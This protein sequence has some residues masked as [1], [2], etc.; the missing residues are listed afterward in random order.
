MG[1]ARNM[2]NTNHVTIL[3]LVAAFATAIYSDD[4]TAPQEA[5]VQTTSIDDN[6]DLIHEHARSKVTALLQAGKTNSECKDLADASIKG[7]TDSITASKQTLGSL[8]TGG[9]CVSSNLVAQAKAAL[10]AAKAT[11]VAAS[12]ADAASQTAPV[13]FADINIV[14]MNEGD[15]A[16]FFN[17]QAYLSAKSA[18]AATAAKN[19]QAIGAQKAAQKAYDDAVAADRAAMRD[20]ACKVQKRLNEAWPTAQKGYQA[21]EA[22]WKRS[23]SMLCVLNGVAPNKCTIPAQ[24]A[25]VKPTLNSKVAKV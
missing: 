3:L 10:D 21:T 1:A 23:H 22:E 5:F 18:A 24:P 11:A 14:D 2:V 25:L 7:I 8:P 13:K 17:D 4:T 20:C 15:C 9:S 6:M 19:S 16:A 12:K